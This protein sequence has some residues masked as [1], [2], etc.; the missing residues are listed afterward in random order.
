[1]IK[2]I[3]PAVIK[4]TDS[5]IRFSN[6]W[7]HFMARFAVN[8]SGHRIEPGLYELGKPDPNSPV[9]VTANYT[10]SFD[11]LRCALKD[12]NCYILVLDTKGVNVWCAAG[13]RTFGT[14]EL[15][16]RISQTGLSDVV[17]H[18]K[19]ILPQLGA[20]GIAAHKVLQQSGFRVE[21]GPVRA[22]DLPD[23]LQTGE[24][25]LQMRRVNFNLR[26]RLVLIPVEFITMLLPAIILA[27]IFYFLSG[28]LA[29]LAIIGAIIAGTVIFPALL[30]WLPT[31]NFSTKG[32]LLGGLA[33]I[34]PLIFIIQHHSGDPLWQ[35]SVSSLSYLLILPAVT[36]FLTLNFTGSTT[37]TSRTG[38]KKEINRYIQ[39]MAWMFGSGI[40][41]FLILRIFA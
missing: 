37:F 13:K 15:V 8:R 28:P 31:A 24:A 39:P 27:T 29:A 16:G 17:S 10:L 19:L 7:D 11:A 34:A 14:E 21:Y 2:T 26:D 25:S 40:I 32:F 3:E 38:V 22:A 4:K 33:A 6:R 36:S 23:Y 20:P 12:Q 1:M 18:R 41:I 9:F 5:Q 30:P 35:N